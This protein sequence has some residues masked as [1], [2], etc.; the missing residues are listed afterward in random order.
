MREVSQGYAMQPTLSQYEEWYRSHWEEIKKEFIT[1][2]SFPSI[3]TDPAYKN[4]LRE[5]A[6]WL[7]E[8]LQKLGLTVELWETGRHP[9]VFATYLKAGKERPTLLLYHHYDVQ[10]VDPLEEWHSDP[11]KPVIKNNKIYARGAVDNKG[12]CFYSITALGAFLKLAAQIGVNIKLFIE[13]EEESGGEGTFALLPQKKDALRADHLLVIDADIPEPGI[14]GI[15][16]GMRGIASMHLECHNSTSDLHSGIMG[17]IVLNP[18]QALIRALA[19]MWDESGKIAIPGFY[20]EVRPV[21]KEELA[22]F[23]GI[24]NLEK[25]RETFGIR[26]FGGEPGYSLLESNWIRPTLEIN[27]ISGGYT[28]VGFKTVIPAKAIAKISC[29]LVPDQD[30]EMVCKRVFNF[31]RSHLPKD[32]ELKV[33]YYKGSKAYRSRFPS[34]IATIAEEAYEEVFRK[35]CRRQLCG[36]SI[37][38]VEELSKLSGAD[39]LTMGVGLSSDEIHAPNEHFGLDRFEQGYLIMGN[40]LSRLSSL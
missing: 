21:S 33:N 22:S 16:L 30:P 26:A 4:A 36:A 25:C 37:P 17:G 6:L 40:I 35:P 9:I 23:D 28:G 2:L 18:N 5:T 27:G 29:R 15:T 1:F 19:K 14:P 24:F 8:F 3:S 10:P 32:L 12:Q 13:G 39:A 11:F 38:I 20:D 34:K 31:I 7:K